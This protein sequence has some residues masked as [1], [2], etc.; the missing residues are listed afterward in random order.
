MQKLAEIENL[1]RGEYG[2]PSVGRDATG[3]QRG[4]AE[5]SPAQRHCL[6]LRPIRI[7]Q[8]IER[9][10]ADQNEAEDESAVQVCPQRDERQQPE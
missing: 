4:D 7:P 9:E 8:G 1:A 6:A 2:S 3:R 10:P 5:H